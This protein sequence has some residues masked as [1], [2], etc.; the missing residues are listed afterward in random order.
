MPKRFIIY[1]GYQFPCDTN[2][3]V[4]GLLKAVIDNNLNCGTDI[5]ITEESPCPKE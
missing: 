1:G 3:A 5:I 2:K 4:I